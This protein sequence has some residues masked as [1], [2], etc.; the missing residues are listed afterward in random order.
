M[1]HIEDIRVLMDLLLNSKTF[2][3]LIVEGVPGWGKST[4]IEGLLRKKM[5]PFVIL[6]SYTTPLRLFTFLSENPNR[7][8]VIDD[9]A[10]VFGDA[11]AMSILK[12]ATWPSSGSEGTRLISWGT[13]SDKIAAEAFLFK[14][15]VILLTNLVPKSGDT[16]AFMSRSLHYRI[17]PEPQE[18]EQLLS[19]I[20][21]CTS[22][23]PNQD[24]S[25]EVVSFLTERAS[26]GGFD[27]VNLRTLKLGYELATS[28]PED[29]KELF[30]RVLPAPDPNHAVVMSLSSLGSVEDQFREFHRRT[31]LSRKT[32]FYHRSR[33]LIKRPRA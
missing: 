4:A 32:F 9:C 30:L 28:T 23:F 7:I 15:K 12:A 10:G 3:S 1:K 18:V 25:R 26:S 13:T 22:E 21:S 20:A 17:S 31:G 5:L 14:G 29:W 16:A 6:G 33:L 8:V 19:S 24:L 27:E 2:H 11:I